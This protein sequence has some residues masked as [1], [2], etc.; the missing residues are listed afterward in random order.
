MEL[1]PAID[2]RGGKA[3]RLLR[4]DYDAETV[5]DD[6][7]VTRAKGFADAGASWVHVVDLDAARTGEQANLSVVE[8]IVAG[9]AGSGCR[10][11]VGGGIRTRETADRL[12]DA[13]VERV[14]IGTAAVEA[15]EVVDTLASQHSGRVAV[16]L[17]VHARGDGS[18]EVAVRGWTE[19]SGLDL[20][21]LAGRFDRPGV[22][23]LI[24]TAIER[25]GTMAGPAIDLYS[26]VLAR[27]GTALVASGGIGSLDDLSAL[28]AVRVEGRS[29]AGAII[30]RAL[31]EERFTL[32][33]AL[34]ACSQPG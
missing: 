20:F 29:L 1:L 4:G 26:E 33:E 11:E 10:V 34:A 12:L 27:S 19:G 30:G 24:V 22:G 14:V 18:G 16:G 6:D 7:P 23:A 28:A 17:D 15:P 31:Y 3:V 9:L 5:Y 21:D 32:E 8:A 13:G 25:D 2:I